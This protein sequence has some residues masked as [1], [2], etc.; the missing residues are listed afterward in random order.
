MKTSQSAWGPSER[1]ANEVLNICEEPTHW[2]DRWER[3][4]ALI[5]VHVA[6]Q[7]TK[8]DEE[9][10]ELRATHDK[11]C[12]VLQRTQRIA[13]GYYGAGV[14][15]SPVA[16]LSSDNSKLRSD[17][18]A[19]TAALEKAQEALKPFAGIAKYTERLKPETGIWFHSSNMP[20][21]SYVVTVQHVRD[22]ARAAS[23]EEG[24]K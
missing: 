14:F 4:T 6:A 5:T 7:T 22:A 17:L 24:A 15:S 12:E 20:S 16:M 18:A 19:K 8:K 11:I 23:T 10:A 9:I 21:E 3:C 1:L 13:D 2:H